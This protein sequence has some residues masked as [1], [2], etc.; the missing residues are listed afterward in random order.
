MLLNELF[1]TKT[2]IKVTEKGPTRC[3]MTF[4]VGDNEYRFIATDDTIVDRADD[5]DWWEI[6][7]GLLLKNPSGAKVDYLMTNTGNALPVFAAVTQC[8]HKLIKMYPDVKK[9]TFSAKTSEPSRIK[10]Y[11]RMIS[12][13]NIPGWKSS[14]EP[15]PHNSSFYLMKT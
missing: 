4:V 9:I 7:F 14:K 13:M 2:T 8:I 10:L 6:A 1:D 5:G 3:V 12:S 11:N 15:G